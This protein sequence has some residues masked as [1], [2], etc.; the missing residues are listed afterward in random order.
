MHANNFLIND[1]CDWHDVENIGEYFPEFQVILPL[2]L[3]IES[4]N[5]VDTSAL[6][7]ASQHEEV[8]GVLDFV[9]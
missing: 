4:I 7:V 5:S 3:V 9:S 2:A 6:V 8:L 1:R